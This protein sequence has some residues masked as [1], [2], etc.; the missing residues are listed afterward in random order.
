M[1]SYVLDRELLL[2]TLGSARNSCQH[3]TITTTTATQNWIDANSNSALLGTTVY[4]RTTDTEMRK[5]M[6]DVKKIF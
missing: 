3:Q 4:Q 5:Q 6:A 2:N 1:S